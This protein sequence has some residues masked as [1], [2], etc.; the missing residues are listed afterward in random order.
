MTLGLKFPGYMFL[1]HLKKG[2]GLSKKNESSKMAS[3]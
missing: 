2:L 3:G 1:A